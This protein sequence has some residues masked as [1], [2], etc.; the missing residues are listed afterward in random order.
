MEKN[1]Q[2]PLVFLS[3]RSK[4]QNRKIKLFVSLDALVKLA[5]CELFL[6]L[7]ILFLLSSSS[8]M[9]FHGRV[10]VLDRWQ[11]GLKNIRTP[12]FERRC[13]HAGMAADVLVPKEVLIHEKLYL[14][15][16][17][18]HKPQTLTEPG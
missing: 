14:V 15:L 3:S 5:F 11:K 9:Q 1:T 7:Y 18:V 8:P 13:I 10:I 6:Y 17:V 12:Q 2:L 4:I 16:I